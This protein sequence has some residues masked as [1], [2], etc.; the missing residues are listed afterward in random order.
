MD[1][2][3]ISLGTLGANELWN[4]RAVRRTGHATTTLIRVDEANIIVDPGLPGEA[5]AA[6]L[7]ERV[8]LSPGEVTHVFLTSFRPG[9]WGGIELFEGAEWLIAEAEREA[10]GVPLA[11]VLRR[12]V[13]SEGAGVV[14]GGG[15]EDGGG[16]GAAVVRMARRELAVLQRCRA[17]PETLV[18]GVDLFPLPG[19]TAGLTGLLVEDRHTTLICG[20]AVPTVDHVLTG[21][22]LPGCHDAGRA[23]ES[24]AE[25]LEIADVLV[26]GR[27]NWVMSPGR[28][29]F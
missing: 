19:V 26:L 1:V 27:D 21:R 20:D 6:R 17:A 24:F 7:G 29:P 12:L 10:A 2:R 9:T 25:A 23:R 8:N 28:S 14:E 11:Q 13:E 5:L 22:V 4:E 18:R 15:G 3:V 16:G